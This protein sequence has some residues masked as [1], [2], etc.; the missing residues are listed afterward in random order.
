VLGLA[1]LFFTWRSSFLKPSTPPRVAAQ[2]E[3]DSLNTALF[4]GTIYWLAGFAALLYPNTA[5]IDPE[6]GP[7]GFPQGPVFAVFAGM[8]MAG[9]AFETQLP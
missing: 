7:P 6:F 3:R 4:V 9:W 1:T 8:A 2:V 5:G